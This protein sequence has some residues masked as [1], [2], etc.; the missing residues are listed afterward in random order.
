M[1]ADD[2]EQLVRLSAATPQEALPLLIKVEPAQLAQ[3][4]LNDKGRHPSHVVAEYGFPSWLRQKSRELEA[5]EEN[6]PE[7]I[8]EAGCQQLHRAEIKLNA[9]L[10]IVKEKLKQ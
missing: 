1:T 10:D 2:L 8:F 9:A 7:W 6:I 4:I 3:A 5:Q